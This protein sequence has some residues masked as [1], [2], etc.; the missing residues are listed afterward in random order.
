VLTKLDQLERAALNHCHM[1]HCDQ[2]LPSR[3]KKEP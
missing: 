1:C 2:V 3:E